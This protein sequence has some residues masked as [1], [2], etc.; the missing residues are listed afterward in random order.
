MGRAN[1][2]MLLLL[3]LL[4]LKY[5]L[6]KKMLNVYFKGKNTDLNSDLKEEPDLKRRCW[7]TLFEPV[8][9]GS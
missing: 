4:L 9:Q 5:I 6:K 3:L 8:M 2:G 1:G 7:F